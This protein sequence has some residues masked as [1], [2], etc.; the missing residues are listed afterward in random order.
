M[1]K[2]DELN[3]SISTESAKAAADFTDAMTRLKGS[4]AGVGRDIGNILIPP[5]TNLVEKAVEMIKKIKDWVDAHKP[6]VEIIIKVGATLGVLAAVGGP[7][8]MAVSA[9]IKMKG[10]IA[11]I[12][13][14]T[15]GP[16]G[17]IILAVGAL[18]IA[19]W[20]LYKMWEENFGGIRDFTDKVIEKMKPA[21]DWLSEK[22]EQVKE[23]VKHLGL[24]LGILKTAVA[25]GGG[26]VG[27]F[28]DEVGTVADQIKEK[29][30][31]TIEE[32]KKMADLEVI[33]KPAEEAIKKII[34]TM[35]PYE[36]KLAAINDRYDEAI[37]KIKE[38]IEDE[39]ELKIATDTLNEGRAAAITLLDREKTALEKVAEAKKR[40]AEL[41]KDLTDKIW[42]F[43]A[44]EEEVKL[45]DINREYDLLIENAKEVFK[46]YNDLRKAIEAINEKRQEE[47]DGLEESNKLK[48]EATEDN[49]DL[50]ESYENLKKPP[51]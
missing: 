26:A 36:K 39:K 4:V 13:T 48:E 28:G 42:E 21:L 18:G 10:A 3:I 2:A 29:L 1:K 20:S 14:V 51:E 19:A 16:I 47:I 43:T 49:V 24:E 30:G 44:T 32:L 22:L 40:L 7:I 34:D 6:L 31:G 37:E 35:T 46:D 17:I 9:F 8:L 41:T 50:K 25:G 12:G 11:L 27:A 33:L 15:S 5:L 45:R 23:V 38:Y